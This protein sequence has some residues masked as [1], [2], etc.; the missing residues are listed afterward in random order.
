MT[1]PTKQSCGQLP[2]GEEIDLYTLV[3]AGGLTVKIVNCGAAIT[4]VEAPDRNGHIDNITLFHDSPA[5]YLLKNKPK[6]GSTVGRYANRIAKGRFTLDGKE[7]VL[8]TNDHGI[9]HLH[10]GLRGFDRVLWQAEPLRNNDA[11]GVVFSYHSP[12]GEEGYP[13]GL[14]V[15][16]TYSLTDGNELKIEYQA[17]CDRPTVVNLTNHAYWNLAGA[18]AGD[19]LGHELTIH[20]DRYLPVDDKLIPL[21]EPRP[22]KDTPLDFTRPET[23]GARIDQVGVGYDHCYVLDKRDGDRSLVPAARVIE[24]RSGRVMEIL[25]T[26]PAVQFYTGNYLDG[27]ITGGG[28]SYRPHFGLCLETQH[29]PDSP[30]HPAY[31]STVLRPGETYRQSTVHRFGVLK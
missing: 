21:G 27:S 15:Q 18:G 31:P 8:A 16:V 9:N 3:N 23:I 19:V 14:A 30:N 12:D 25:T 7:Y 5:D 2:T 6:F 28:K 26:Q 24:A 13:G 11:T 22:V 17:T 4:D 29:Y 10:G 20:A 1:G